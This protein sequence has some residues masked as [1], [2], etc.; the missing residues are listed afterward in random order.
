M[1]REIVGNEERKVSVFIL[2]SLHVFGRQTSDFGKVYTNQQP[3][4]TDNL[5]L[6]GISMN[7]GRNWLVRFEVNRISCYK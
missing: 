1:I 2:A 4:S 6:N 5:T 7:I 3:F